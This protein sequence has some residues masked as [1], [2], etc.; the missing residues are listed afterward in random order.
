MALSYS[1]GNQRNEPDAVVIPGIDLPIVKK[2]KIRKATEAVPC[3]FIVLS[4]RLF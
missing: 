2:K 3:L 4:D 1:I